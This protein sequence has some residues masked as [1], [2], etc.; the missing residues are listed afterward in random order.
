MEHYVP[1]DPKCNRGVAQSRHLGID[2]FEQCHGGC[3]MGFVDPISEEDVEPVRLL[4]TN[5]EET[6]RRRKGAMLCED[7][8]AL[9]NSGASVKLS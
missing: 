5:C 3:N 7:C 2:H 9:L 1:R 6:P 4:C 8:L